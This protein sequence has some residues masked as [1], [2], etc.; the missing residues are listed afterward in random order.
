[1]TVPPVALGDVVRAADPGFASGQRSAD[2]ILQIRMN[3]V[4]SDGALDLSVA[5]RVPRIP[6]L[7]RYLLE[8]GDVLFNA[9]N[10]PELVGKSA[11][12]PGSDEPV[13]Y[14]NHFL[15][16]RARTDRLEPT[17]LVRW[18]SHEWKRR[19]FEGMCT[20]WVNQASIRKERLLQLKLPLPSLAEQ[21]RIAAVL[22]KA[23]GIRRKRR[24]SLLLLDEFLRSAFL[25]MFGDPVTNE[26]GWEVV[27]GGD[28][29]EDLRYG[30]SVKCSSRPTRSSRPVLRIPNVVDGAI[31]WDDLK[32]VELSDD[33][34]RRLEL[35]E[36]DLLFVRTNGNPEYIGRCAVFD[37]RRGALYASYLIRGQLKEEARYRP[38]FLK[39]VVSFP[40]YRVRLVAESRSTAGNYNINIERL[41]RLR[42][43]RP[44]LDRQD[45]FLAVENG[46]EATRRAME[47]SLTEANRLFDSLAQRAFR[48]EL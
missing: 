45:R 4:D 29:F 34:V 41:K 44:P 47:P 25:E 43:I 21:R 23:D 18:L 15:R 8:P 33:E 39:S 10:S 31:R 42:F 12:F 13:T 26:K 35:K 3:C 19:V 24:E 22:D 38:E 30:T 17:Y 14:S 32:F 5:P 37:G 46:V 11:F 7:A 28:V 48:G 6:Q 16:L 36:G 9:T 40:S 2:G 27:R 20:Q 1:M